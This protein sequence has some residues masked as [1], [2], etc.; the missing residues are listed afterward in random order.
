MGK[1]IKHIATLNNLAAG[2]HRHAIADGFDH[3]HLMG[4]QH[5]RD[6]KLRVDLF[7][8]FQNGGRGFQIQ[9]GGGSSHNSTSG[10]LA[11]AR[12]IP[13][14]CFCPPLSCTG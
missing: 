2:H 7:E 10:W 12:A 11:I 4:D 6:A 1:N 9:R 14:R 8:Q 5:D 13:T 3:V